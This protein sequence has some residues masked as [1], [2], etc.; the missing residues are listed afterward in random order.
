MS[1]LTSA[2]RATFAAVADALLP[3][4]DGDGR[5][6]TSSAAELGIV[7][8]LDGQV[9]RLPDQ[10]TREAIRRLLRT[11][12]TSVGGMILFGR[13]RRFT[14]LSTDDASDALRRMAGSRIPRRR[15]AFQALKRLVAIVA[16]TAPDQS[17]PSPIWNDIG[18]PGPDVTVATASGPITPIRVEEP[19]TWEADVVV[20]GSGAGGATAAA[21]LSLAGLD[22]VILEKG[23]FLTERQFTHLEHDAYARL[24]LDGN[25]APT[26]DLG[27]GMQA[28]SCLGGGTV[29]NYTVALPTPGHVREEWDRLTGFANAFSADDYE[30]SL[31][32]V[33]ERIGA[34]TQHS[35]PSRQE[36]LM[37]AGL[38]GLGWQVDDVPRNVEGCPQDQACGYCTMGCRR[39]AVR[40]SLRTWLED[41]HARGT[42]IVVNAEATRVLMDQRRAVGVEADVAGKRL[43]VS[44]RAIVVACGGLYTPVLLQ[45]SAAGGNSVGRT[46]WLHPTT[47]V[48]GRFPDEV[49]PWTGTVHSKYGA[50][51]ANLDGEHYGVTFEVGPS[52]P[53]V[54]ALAFGWE[55]G[56]Q[57]KRALLDYPYWGA[58]G[59]RLRDRDH[60]EVVVPKTGRPIW[61]YRMSR[62]D[63]AHVRVGIR[64]AAQVLAEAGAQEVMTTSG[65]PVTWRPGGEH[66]ESF[67]SR[68]DSIGYDRNGV[69]YASYHQMGTARMGS[70]PRTSTIDA[71]CRVH[72]TAGLYVMDASAFPATSGVNPMVTIEALAHRAATA[73]AAELT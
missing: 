67:M 63:Q 5:F 73:L 32:L 35:A 47:A 39:G 55:S 24:Y 37:V 23:D 71:A 4:L 49:R 10:R 36:A 3:A 19:A 53:V 27:I 48:W 42:R 17:T 38:Q 21:V 30:Q 70:N 62:R 72:G 13:P 69:L 1:T 60:G 40:S 52:H 16:V 44:A 14:R 61:R 59:V 33:Q 26:E 57:Y 41:A 9:A 56:R 43:T 15:E 51:F 31:R 46:L 29:I 22:V 65:T 64:G 58:V 66:I 45:R 25:L 12:D 54:A 50:Q 11:L 6:W 68:V 2:E 28:G 8:R 18:Y 20:V 7:R 34:N